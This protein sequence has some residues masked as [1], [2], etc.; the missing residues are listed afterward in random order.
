VGGF[1]YDPIFLPA[2]FE[3]TAAEL[4]AQT[5]NAHSHRGQALR[6]LTA[7]M[8]QRAA[9]GEWSEGKVVEPGGS[10]AK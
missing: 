5:K 2:G 7:Q 8:R 3:Q 1:G 6:S 10:G 9:L 4:T